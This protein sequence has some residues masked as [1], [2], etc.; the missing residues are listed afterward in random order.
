MMSPNRQQ[1]PDA[2][3]YKCSDTAPAF[4]GDTEATVAFQLFWVLLKG[5]TLSQVSSEARDGF[6]R[7]TN[8][9]IGT[10]RLMDVHESREYVGHHRELV[11]LDALESDDCHI[12]KD[13]VTA[14]TGIWI[15][16]GLP[17]YWYL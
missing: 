17:V 11:T 2:I 8:A 5:D 12:S 7:D 3:S 13:L 16:R 1:V 15:L 14:P 4:G 10:Q 9:I 6:A